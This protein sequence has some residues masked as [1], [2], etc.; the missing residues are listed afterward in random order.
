MNIAEELGK[1]N[2]QRENLATNL[3]AKGVTVSSS[4]TLAQL[5]PKVLDITSGEGGGSCTLPQASETTLGGVKA[6]PRT[7]E[8]VEVAIDD[9][10]GKLYIPGASAGDVPIADVSEHFIATDVEG[11]LSELFTSVSSGKG[12][13]AGAITDKG[14][15]AS[16]N[17]SFSVMASKIDSILQTRTVVQRYQHQNLIFGTFTK[18]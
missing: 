6:K 7:T 5:V 18:P 16:A 9:T 4:E 8:S 15:A 10:T 12:L 2:T 14:V 13:I 3:T 11:A 1:L 17:D